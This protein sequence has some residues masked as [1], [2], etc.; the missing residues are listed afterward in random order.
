[1]F[2]KSNF[3]FVVIDKR[4]FPIQRYCLLYSFTLKLFSKKRRKGAKKKIFEST[5]MWE[6]I[7]KAFVF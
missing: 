3:L 6:M 2:I 7:K 5:Q 1:M 4:N